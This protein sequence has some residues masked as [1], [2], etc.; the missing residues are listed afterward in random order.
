[1]FSFFNEL[2]LLEIRLNELY[3]KVDKFVILEAKQTFQGK[4]NPLIFQKNKHLFEKFLDKIIY[5]SIHKNLNTNNPWEIESYQRGQ[6]SRWLKQCSL[7]DII[8][9]S[10]VDEII[11]ADAIDRIVKSLQQD[12]NVIVTCDQPLYRH[13]LNI[14]DNSSEWVGTIACTYRYLC[15]KSITNLRLNR[16]D[17]NY[18][19]IPDAGWHFSSM[20]GDLATIS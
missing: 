19:I 15:N 3:E 18:S 9:I 11:R 20:G 14:K 1:L 17:N 16:N 4:P 12:R 5:I 7:N 2:E 6:L 8:L 10:D 13:F